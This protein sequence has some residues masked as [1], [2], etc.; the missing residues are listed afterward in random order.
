MTRSGEG[1]PLP[2]DCRPRLLAPFALYPDPG[3]PYRSRTAHRP[4]HCQ[5]ETDEERGRRIAAQWTT[6]P[7]AASRAEA[8]ED[9]GDLIPN[10]EE[11][12]EFPDPPHYTPPSD[13]LVD[14]PEL[15]EARQLS[16]RLDAEKRAA[17]AKLSHEEQNLYD[18]QREQWHIQM[19]AFST[20]FDFG[21][22][23]IFYPYA[24]RCF[25]DRAVQFLYKVCFYD[26]ATQLM[27]TYPAH[28][29]NLG[30][31]TGL[32]SDYSQ[33][34]FEGGD[35]CDGHPNRSLRVFFHCSTEEKLHDTTEPSTCS[36]E[37]F[38]DT[39][40]ACHDHEYQ[41]LKESMEQIEAERNKIQ[42]EIEAAKDEL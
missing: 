12:Y 30:V 29:V 42:A 18:L 37:T 8:A 3:Y 1:W 31:W 2:P 28:S 7:D 17:E 9:E 14:S 23:Q 26:R 16:A 19:F 20:D 4:P 21:P 6:D 25:E 38:L 11:P 22:N 33:A 5:E 36:Y 34:L 40:L 13:L 24:G 10:E 35:A 27:P 15:L 41:K 32:T 39:P